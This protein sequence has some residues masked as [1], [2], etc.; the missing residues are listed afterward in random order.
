VLDAVAPDAEA[1]TKT[2]P[3]TAALSTLAI[4]PQR[5]RPFSNQN[6]CAV[7]RRATSASTTDALCHLLHGIIK[8]SYFDPLCP[9][10]S[11]SLL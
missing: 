5:Q 7:L 6:E 11:S 9:L 2:P 3:P 10:F 1:K 8:S 4:A